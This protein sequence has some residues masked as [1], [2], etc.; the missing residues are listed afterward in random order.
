MIGFGSPWM[1]SL[2]GGAKGFAGSKS[3]TLGSYKSSLSTAKGFCLP[4]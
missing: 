2:G 4:N 3:T 1:F